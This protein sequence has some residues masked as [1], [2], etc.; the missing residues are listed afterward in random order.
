MWKQDTQNYEL[1]NGMQTA[2]RR[3]RSAQ[4]RAH[5]SQRIALTEKIMKSSQS[6]NKLF[7]KLI[8]NQRRSDTSNPDIMVFNKNALENPEEIS[9][10]WRDYFSELFNN[11]IE[12]EIGAEKLHLVKIQNEI[13]EFIEKENLQPIERA[14]VDEVTS[15]ICKMKTGKSPDVNGISSEHFK[16]GPEEI[17]PYIVFIINLIF[18]NLDVPEKNEIWNSYFSIKN[19]QR[20]EVPRKLQG[21]SGEVKVTQGVRQGAKLS[22]MLYKRYNNNILKALERSEIGAEI[23]NIKVMAPTCADDIAVLAENQHEVQALLDIVENCTKRDLVTINPNK[24]DL[25]PITKCQSNFSVYLGKDEITQKSETK[26]LGLIRN[27]KN[28]LNTED[29][30]KLARKTLYA[31]LEPGLHARK[32]MSPIVAYKNMENICHTTSIIWNRSNE[33]H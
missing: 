8:Q 26:H 10:G 30:L 6:D 32:G 33:F 16:Y 17:I 9:D 11:D 19:R 5:A 12:N 24:S 14:T 4:R 1:K 31:L 20:Q 13:I 15:S 3:V 23:G 29:R 25:V 2:K 27:S 21:L 28:K 18:D 22:T 7:H